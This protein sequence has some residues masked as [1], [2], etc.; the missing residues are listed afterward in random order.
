MGKQKQQPESKVKEGWAK[1][2]RFQRSESDLEAEYYFRGKWHPAKTITISAGGAY[3]ACRAPKIRDNDL[4]DLV[5]ILEGMTIIT[6]SRVVW[7][8]SKK[9]RPN[10]GFPY[11]PGFAI[12]FEKITGEMRAAVDQY[13]KKSLRTLKTLV[14]ELSL[15]IADRE[16]IIRLFISLRPGDST[17]LNHI[18]KI[19]KQEFRHFRLRKMDSYK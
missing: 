11:P 8:N 5:F 7:V 17:R 12:E 4:I 18:R 2:R 13:V 9:M 16:K 15:P 1:E 3:L 6:I 19:V 14:Y 10:Q